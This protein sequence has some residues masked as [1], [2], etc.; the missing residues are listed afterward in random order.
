MNVFDINLDN[1]DRNV[2]NSYMCQ[3]MERDDDPVRPQ[4]VVRGKK[5]A[6]MIAVIKS[7]LKTEIRINEIIKQYSD[8]KRIKNE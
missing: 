7:K 3:L 1:G 5:R 4:Y 2:V 6:K 8:Y